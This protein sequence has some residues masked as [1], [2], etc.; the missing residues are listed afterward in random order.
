MKLKHIMRPLILKI[1]RE[2]Q[3]PFEKLIYPILVKN[4]R[5]E[6][7]T[8]EDKCVNFIISLMSK[9]KSLTPCMDAVRR[10]K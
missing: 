4:E 10:N 2:V 1:L 6:H 8:K 9:L 5:G 3:K 7:I